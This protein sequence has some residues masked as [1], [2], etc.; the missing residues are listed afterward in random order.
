[1][2]ETLC[3]TPRFLRRTSSSASLAPG[4]ASAS[5][6]LRPALKRAS[7]TGGSSTAPSRLALSTLRRSSSFPRSHDLKHALSRADLASEASGPSRATS[8][9]VSAAAQELSSAARRGSG[10]STAEHAHPC[11]QSLE[12]NTSLAV[13]VARHNQQASYNSFAVLNEKESL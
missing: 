8:A 2:T 13:C 12:Q 4:S 11:Y 6:R 3:R 5:P 7:Y 9:D 1:M 10:E